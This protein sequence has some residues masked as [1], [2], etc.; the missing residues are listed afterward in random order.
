MLMVA[1]ILTR[2]GGRLCE[3]GAPI[4]TGKA[5]DIFDQMQA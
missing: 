1:T 3:V 5:D 4:L 2:V